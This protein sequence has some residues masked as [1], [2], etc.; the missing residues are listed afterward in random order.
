MSQQPPST[1]RS[2]GVLAAFAAS[3]LPYAAL[4]LPVY[5]T[6]PEFYAS[7]IGVDLGLVGAV[8]LI[9]RLADVLVDPFLGALIDRTST[10]WG[11][12]R[13]WMGIGAPIL[14]L[15]VFMLFMVE[16]GA[17]AAHLVTW[18]VV[19][20]LG[21]S[22]SVL[23]QTSWAAVLSPDYDQ[24]SRVYAWWQ[25]ANIVGVLAVL[26]IPVIVQQGGYGDYVDA[27]RLQGW[28]IL[29]ALPITLAITFRFVPEPKDVAPPAH[30]GLNAYLSLFR[31]PAVRRLLVSDLMLGAG[32]GTV[33]VLFFYFF[34]S[35][36][37][38]DRA[39]TSTL[40]A[41][42]FVA[43]LVGAPVWAKLAYKIGKHGAL[44]VASVYFAVTLAAT[45]LLVPAGNFG[46]AAAAIFA[47]GLA[48]GAADLLLRAMMADVSDEVKLAQNADRTA[49]LFSILTATSKLGYAVSVGT[50][51]LLKAAGFNPAPGA[52]NTP[53]AILGLEWLFTGLPVALL[54]VSAW[55]LR[56]YPLD[57]RRH[58]EIRAALDAR[59]A[60]G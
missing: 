54:L 58:A 49:L 21:F 43:G 7:H 60:A 44:A 56:G 30:G 20:Y 48:F 40:L 33:A 41:I 57:Q 29:A 4:G 38:F 37:G 11:R 45:A 46:I 50:F 36:R 25:A 51:M 35:A 59:V 53:E 24:R 23:S 5:V 52:T 34:E 14:L 27:V 13:V 39:Q 3:C 22:I 8:F 47:T 55:V 1:R 28:F 15:S 32:R 18:L 19:M 31:S 42:Y 16:R 6:L 9:I 26:A 12:Y 2:N 10:K 17:G